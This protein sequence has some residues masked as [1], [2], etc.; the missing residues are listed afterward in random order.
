[1]VRQYKYG[2]NPPKSIVK[3][4]FKAF[5]VAEGALFAGACYMWFK[6]GVKAWSI[7]FL[8]NFRKTCG[9][10]MCIKKAFVCR[11]HEITMQ[12]ARQIVSA[13]MGE[14]ARNYIFPLKKLRKFYNLKRKSPY[15]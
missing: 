14:D 6:V 13:T 10:G 4:Y 2:N 12:K 15:L 1:M 8:L 9:F 3:R 5:I 7:I 11:L